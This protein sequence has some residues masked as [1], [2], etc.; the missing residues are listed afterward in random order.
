MST[1][2]DQVLNWGPVSRV[3]RNHALEHATLQVLAEKDHNLRM[4]GY[5]DPKGFWLLGEIETSKVE[6]A[7]QQALTRLRSGESNL[8]IHPN[9]GTNLVT[10][11]FIAGALAWLG[12]L[13]ADRNQ[14]DRWERLP[15]VM[16]LAT[17][18]MLLAQPVGPY[19]QKHVTTDAASGD[20][21]V[22]G[23]ERTKRG[24]VPLHRVLTRF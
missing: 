1:T 18:G 17:I 13:T 20:L 14:R 15:M 2:L 8:A 21:E 4:A 5:S 12:M 19:I 10:T 6:E 3:R 11:G 16:S 7:V 23:I 24:D 22:I 9:C